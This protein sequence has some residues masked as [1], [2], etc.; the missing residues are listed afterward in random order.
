ME[1]LQKKLK[2]LK[3]V[4]KEFNKLYYVDISKKVGMKKEELE[5]IQMT[6]LSTIDCREMIEKEKNVAEEL[7]ELMVAEESFYKQKS[8]I[9][10]LKEGDENTKFFHGMVA[11]RQHKNT[12][13]SL[14]W[15]KT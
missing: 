10:W 8:R 2:R 4:L 3:T 15:G 13:L 14:Q 7:H 6:N 5:G 12:I 1:V 9:Q 11:A